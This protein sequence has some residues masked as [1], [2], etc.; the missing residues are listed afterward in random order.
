M[1]FQELLHIS[2]LIMRS[3]LRGRI[4][5]CTRPSVRSVPPIFSKLES[6]RNFLIQ[7]KHS[8]GQE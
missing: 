5:R 7:R 1:F 3:S 4:N 6:R 8:A 2:A